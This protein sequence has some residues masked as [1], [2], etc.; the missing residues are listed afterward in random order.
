[1]SAQSKRLRLAVGMVD[2]T[3]EVR[4]PHAA[5][6]V[7]AYRSVDM[8]SHITM[9]Y[10]GVHEHEHQALRSRREHFRDALD[11]STRPKGDLKGREESAVP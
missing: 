10:G 9:E 2:Y 6:D 7:C 5:A 11:N 8:Q 4:A 1:M 3:L